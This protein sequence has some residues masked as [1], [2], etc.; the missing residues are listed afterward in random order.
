M[1]KPGLFITVEGIEGVGKTTNIEF[2]RH[3]M[4]R[5]G[6]AYV[7]TREPGGTPLAEEIREVLLQPREEA[8]CDTSELLLVFAARAQ[9]LAHMIQPNIQQGRWVLCDRFTDATYAYQGGGR[10]LSM[11]V[12]GTLENL[13]QG[14]LRP[15]AVIL[16]DVPVAVGLARASARGAPDRIEKEKAEFFEKVRQTYLARAEADP[17]RYHLVDASQDLSGVQTQLERVLETILA[18]Y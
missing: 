10:G 5:Q 12:I 1:T 4:K 15:D 14:D 16:L 11:E 6:I 3:W 8:V 17:E 13:V 9:H 18:G 2:I 7:A